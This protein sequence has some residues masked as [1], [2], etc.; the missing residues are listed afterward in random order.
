MT[1]EELKQK[2]KESNLYQWQVANAVGVSEMTLIRWLRT[3]ITK[4]H[5]EQVNAAIEFLKAGGLSE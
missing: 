1:N 3:P 5:A 4:E 2:I